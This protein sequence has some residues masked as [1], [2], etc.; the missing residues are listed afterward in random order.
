MDALT[1]W[2]VTDLNEAFVTDNPINEKTCREVVELLFDFLSSALPRDEAAAFER[3]L[4][5][6]PDCLAYLKG[7]RDAI[8]L[9]KAALGEPDGTPQPPIDEALVQAIVAAAKKRG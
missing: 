8:R 9:G 7:Y 5:E 1:G 2:C 6:C 4:A 3:H